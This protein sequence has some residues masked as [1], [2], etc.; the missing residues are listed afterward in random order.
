MKRLTLGILT[1]LGT[2]ATAFAQQGRVSLELA[3][4]TTVEAG[5]AFRIE[6]TINA[7]GVSLTSPPT[8]EGFEVLAGPS[9]STGTSIQII[10]RE[11][12]Q[13]STT[14]Y[15]YVIRGSTAGLHTIGAAKV[16]VGSESYS[17]QPVSVEVVASHGAGAGSGGGQ[18][19]QGQ[20]QARAPEIGADD[21]LLR[22]TANNTEVY[23][24]EPVVVTL[25]FYRRINA[26][27][28]DLKIPTFN[29]FWQQDISPAEPAQ[30]RES[31][32]GRAYDT[33]VLKEYL[34]YPQQ[35]GTLTIDP[36]KVSV[37]AV[38]QVQSAPSRNIFD[39]FFGMGQNVQEV[40][41]EVAS[42]PL[43]I[44]VREWPEE[45]RPASFDGAVGSFTLEAT[46]PAATMGANSSA[47][48][49]L[50]LSGTGN[51]PLLRAPKLQ[52]PQSFESYDVKTLDQTRDGRGGISGNKEFS[53][54]F[55]P[56]TDGVYTIPAF[57]FSYFDPR[58]R[59]Y[60]TLSSGE[61]S[62]EVTADTTAVRGVA[63]GGMVGGVSRD[64]LQVFGQDIQFIK[65][66]GAGL[67]PK[68][69]TFMMSAAYLSLAALLVALFVA[70]L[71]VLPRWL[72]N[73]QSDSFVRGKRA[74]KVALRRFRAAEACMKR[75]D[76]H[77]FHDEM[78]K[79]LWGYMGDKFNIPMADLTRERI[80]EEL[81][82]RSIPEAQS[83][84]YV[85][86]IAECE[87]AQYSPLSST[88]MNELYGHGVSLIS[89]LESTIN[90][91]SN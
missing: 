8:F 79:A 27:L 26:G 74:N 5:E 24:G 46:P 75:G 19:A 53:Y 50:R 63:P 36:F 61:V 56:R 83:D 29:G 45:G 87:Q 18:A 58:Q 15:T 84:E 28:E 21:V 89:E 39:E 37:N 44:V 52:L 40:R 9:E 3:A 91:K 55:I 85:R 81:F 78:L 4:P 34:L 54:P 14:T 90:K 7:Q 41:G 80:R 76:R 73:M 20:R 31:L 1:L 57:E 82:V 12:T 49:T 38:F 16:A 77:G 51:F 62:I 67:R 88:G 42:Q 32:G 6:L 23:K 35:S 70:G 66:G 11:R 72:R 68:G 33:W 60:T 25:K 47:S 30:Q 2:I 17:S 13:T 64:E 86:I 48:Y 10:N 65:R 43:R 59:R 71:V 22:A 69:R